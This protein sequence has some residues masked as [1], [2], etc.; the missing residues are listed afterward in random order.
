M[1]DLMVADNVE[2]LV[3]VDNATDNLS[4]VPAYV[5]TELSRFWRRGGRLTA[6][7]ALCCAAHGLSCAITVW[8]NGASKTL[9][10]D[11][12]PDAS[13]FE[14][15]V[16]R[17]G[18][19]IG[20]VDGLFLSHGHWDH[21]GAMLRALDLM[22]V[23]NKGADMPTFMHPGMYATRAM[24]TPDGKIRVMDDVPTQA[25][26]ERHGARVVHSKEAQLVLDDMFFIS[27]EIPRTTV[28]ERGMPG[29]IRRTGDGTGWE[30]DP[31]RMDERFVAVNVKDKGVLVFSAC[32]HAGVVNVL[33]HAR[34]SFPSA[35]VYGVMGGFHLSG[36]TESIIPQTV[37]A[38]RGFDLKAIAAGHCTGWRAVGALAA[39]FGDAV[40]PTSVGKTY[41]F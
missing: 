1:S 38:L 23:R 37:E 32:S 30:P 14:R 10:F 8:R 4:S 13:V 11:T 34:A 21:A 6:G 39:A 25:E 40:M 33:G 35:G 41:R 5:E 27:G 28:F 15:N 20:S 7:N 12:G 36:A 3:L 22:Q 31:L 17:L 9:L 19:D 18:F 16:D 24:R 2:V 29:Q 26:L